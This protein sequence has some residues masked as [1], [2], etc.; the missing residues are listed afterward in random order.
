MGRKT[1]EGLPPRFRPLPDRL[2]VVLSRNP[3]I[4]TDLTIPDSVVIMDS[5]ESALQTL[6]SL[7]MNQTVDKIFVIGGGAIYAQ[8]VPLS[9]CVKVYFTLVDQEFPDCDTFFPTLSATQF[10]M[11]SRSSPVA[12]NG[13]TYRFA[14]FDAISAEDTIALPSTID[15]AGDDVENLEEMQYL[16]ITRDIIESGIL[17]GD[18]TGT[19]TISKFGV[20][21]RFS[22]RG[23]VFPLLT[24]KKV[25]WR[26]VVEELLWFIKG[27]TNA[28]ELSDR[29]VRIWDANGSREFL[30]KNGLSHREEGDL[31]P[32]YGFQVG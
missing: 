1:Y 14:E 25:F 15:D 30:D 31:G 13:I 22:L 21:M 32:V 5:L 9:Q 2:N 27:S 26:G 29:G 11:V 19:G 7:D 16:N 3:T 17:R 20:Q 10:R 4:R 18:R 24:S 8:A 23:G 6:S 12:E 28:K